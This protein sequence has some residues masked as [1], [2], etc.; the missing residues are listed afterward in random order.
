MKIVIEYQYWLSYNT[1]VTQQI[2]MYD[3]PDFMLRKTIF[4]SFDHQ[5][6]C[7][8][9]DDAVENETVGRSTPAFKKTLRYSPGCLDFKSRTKLSHTNKLAEKLLCLPIL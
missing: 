5:P 3:F 8:V 2:V 4:L 7:V 1:S 9:N 6:A